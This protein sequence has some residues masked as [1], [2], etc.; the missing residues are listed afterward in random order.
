MI[1]FVILL[2][3][4]SSATSQWTQPTNQYP[5]QPT[6]AFSP[7]AG[8]TSPG[9]A[10]TTSPQYSSLSTAPGAPAEQT[11]KTQESNTGSYT[12]GEPY[13]SITTST[14]SS[15]TTEKPYSTTSSET[16]DKPYS[17]TSSET[18]EKPYSKTTERSQ[19]EATTEEPKKIVEAT[20]V[21]SG[22]NERGTNSG[23]QAD[24]PA[25]ESKTAFPGKY[26]RLT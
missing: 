20:L 22:P 18:T 2:I 13:Q 19:E 23:N 15:E 16:T 7:S 14:T 11:Y 8:N 6:Q 25:S 10:G 5:D 1:S 21:E 9:D 3:L 24:I 4:S 17:T 26:L 12:T